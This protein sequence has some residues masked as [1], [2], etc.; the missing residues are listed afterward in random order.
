MPVW[1]CAYIFRFKYHTTLYKHE[2]TYIYVTRACMRVNAY[3][4]LTLRHVA[5]TLSKVNLF[6]TAYCRSRD[7]SCATLNFCTRIC[8]ENLYRIDLL[9][10]CFGIIFNF[11]EW[12]S[13]PLSFFLN[14]CTYYIIYTLYIFVPLSAQIKKKQD[15]FALLAF[16]VK[17]TL[18]S[19][20][21]VP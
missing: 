10:A 17:Y 18:L 14:L 5:V 4:L 7:Q 19:I 20:K 6:F 3:T 2:Y 1:C 21:N 9:S 12:L 11:S 16:V 8:V 13:I 15:K